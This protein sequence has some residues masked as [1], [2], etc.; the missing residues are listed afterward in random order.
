L[1]IESNCIAQSSTASPAGTYT[2]PD[3]KVT[4]TWVIAGD[5]ITFDLTGKT[6]G[7]VAIGISNSAGMPNSDIAHGWIDI[8]NVTFFYAR[9]VGSARNLP[10]RDSIQSLKLISSLQTS[11]TTNFKWSRKLA[12]PAPYVAITNKPFYL[13]WAYND[14]D[15]TSIDV[16]DQ[17]LT[18]TRGVANVNFFTGTVSSLDTTKIKIHALLMLASW[19]V[20]TVIAVF[21]ARFG[22]ISFGDKWF[23]IHWGLISTAILCTI[24][25]FCLIVTQRQEEGLIHFNGDHEACGLVTVFL[26][27]VQTCFGYLADKMFNPERKS[28][29][30]FPDKIHWWLGRITATFALITIVLGLLKNGANL[31]GPILFCVFIAAV[32]ILFIIQQ[33]TR[34]SVQHSDKPERKPGDRNICYIL[35][36]LCILVYIPVATSVFIFS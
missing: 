29:P 24:T 17:H 12:L 10:T 34:G 14:N 1:S 35:T 11:T 18:T 20:F 31:W 8:N 6:T 30:I 16:F 3:G 36:A 5:E 15:G 19:G 13:I 26:S 21:V 7:W 28:I 33:C 22:K 23:P 25:A 9:N 32:Y 4:V 2:S 27:L